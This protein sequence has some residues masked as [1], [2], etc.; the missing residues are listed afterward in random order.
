MSHQPILFYLDLQKN[1]WRA[2]AALE[3]SSAR[4]YSMN[5]N[6][7]VGN[8]LGEVYAY[9]ASDGLV[10]WSHAFGGVMRGIG[11]ADGVIYAGTLK[12]LLY[13]YMP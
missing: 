4:P 11:V 1:I 6:V 12:G 7:L 9:R 10:Q 2:E 3:W 5:G 13:A 8:N